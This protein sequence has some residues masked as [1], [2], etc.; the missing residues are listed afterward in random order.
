[1]ALSGVWRDDPF[2]RATRQNGAVLS[3]AGVHWV[4]GSGG[5]T[6]AAA[7]FVA[8]NA[9]LAAAHNHADNPLKVVT[10]DAADAL[11]V[12]GQIGRLRPGLLADFVLWSAD[13]SDPAA[14]VLRVYVGGDLVYQ[15]PDEAKKGETK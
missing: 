7:Q 3:A 5:Q 9:Q 13:P 11:R 8:F 14:K 4:V 1:M 2:R 6:T 12:G 15:A 10:A